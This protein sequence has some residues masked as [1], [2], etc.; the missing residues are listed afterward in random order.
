MR[1]VTYN[2]L[3]A[4]GAYRLRNISNEIDAHIIG[5]TGTRLPS[6]RPWDGSAHRPAVACH[7]RHFEVRW[8]VRED[9]MLEHGCQ[10]VNSHEQE[11]LEAKA[12]VEHVRRATEI[13]LKSEQR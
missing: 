6:Y 11:T 9:E 3:S 13:A 2:V 5:L 4:R 7:G 1:V 10:G 12:R 8:E